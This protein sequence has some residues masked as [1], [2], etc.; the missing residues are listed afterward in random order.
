ML[1]PQPAKFLMPRYF[2]DIHNGSA[3]SRD[4]IGTECDGSEGIRY[5]AMRTL[6]A[7]ARDEIPRDGDRQAFTVMVRDERNVTVYTATLT[8]AGLWVGA[9]ILA[10]EEPID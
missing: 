4:P 6:P 5:E 10:A 1:P 9:D 3:L 8:F 7:I 2:F